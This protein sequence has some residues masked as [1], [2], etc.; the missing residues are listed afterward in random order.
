MRQFLAKLLMTVGSSLVV[1]SAAL[2]AFGGGHAWPGFFV[3]VIGITMIIQIDKRLTRR[4]RKKTAL[5]QPLRVAMPKRRP[6]PVVQGVLP[7]PT[8]PELANFTDMASAMPPVL[9]DLIFDGFLATARDISP[10][11]DG[12]DRR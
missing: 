6:V 7:A 4:R 11:G 5:P 8:A 12:R 10:G 2:L 9:R 3:L 1:G